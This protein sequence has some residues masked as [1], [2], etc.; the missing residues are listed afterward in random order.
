MVRCNGQIARLVARGH[1]DKETFQIDMKTRNALGLKNWGQTVEVE[2]GEARWWDYTLWAIRSSQPVIRIS[3]WMSL[4]SLI[5]G[6]IGLVLGVISLW[7]AGVTAPLGG[8]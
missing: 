2:I 7:V 5:L 1:G 6:V 4:I 3:A 8:V